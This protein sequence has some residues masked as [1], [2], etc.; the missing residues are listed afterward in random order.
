MALEREVN[1]IRSSVALSTL[2]H[3][4]Q[5]RLS[6]AGAF[7]TLDRLCSAELFLRDGQLLH[8]LLLSEDGRPF[9]DIYVGRDD[10]ELVLLSEGPSAEQLLAHLRSHA[11]AGAQV[12][13]RDLSS[14]HE[15]LG[16]NGPYAWE[17]LGELEGPETI[18]LPY[19]AFFHLEGG[20]CFRAGKT[21]EYGYTLSVPRDTAPAT[22]ERLEELGASYDLATAG[23]AALDHCALENWFFN[24]R[25]EGLARVTP[26]E[27]QLQW[28][29]SAHKQ[30]LGSAAVEARRAE[31]AKQRLT[32]LCA[33]AAF[34]AGDPVLCG[35]QRIG[36]VANAAF[37]FARQDWVGLAFL[38]WAY[39]HSGID[40]YAV[41][42]QGRPVPVR[43]MSPPVLNNR[44]LYVDPQRHSYRTR[45]E[46]VVPP[47]V[48]RGP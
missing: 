45:A 9:A 26:V 40:R 3:V 17:L 43:T 29:V 1:A 24:I 41:V 44:S 30:Y 6:G 16:L 25:R 42:H 4:A 5:V 20:T 46:V 12:E 7:D 28:R 47:L 35:E 8:S 10:E 37:S 2:G 21:G 36:Q 22:R 38:D 32:C 11:P 31:G 23:L 34:E 14:T 39:A 33:A 15:L 19:L 18:G 48:L 13:F 27:L